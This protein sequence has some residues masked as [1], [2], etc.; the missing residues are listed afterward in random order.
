MLFA[1]YYMQVHIEP[2]KM[3]IGGEVV[4]YTLPP[5]EDQE[6]KYDAL[7]YDTIFKVSSPYFIGGLWWYHTPIL[8][9]RLKE[10]FKSLILG[11][12]QQF[13]NSIDETLQYYPD[14]L[15]NVV[16]KYIKKAYN[17][18]VHK[19]LNRSGLPKLTAFQTRLKIL[20]N[21]S[22]LPEWL[23][24]INGINCVDCIDKV[25]DKIILFL[26]NTYIFL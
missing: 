19:L 3:H 15:R 2:I 21:V 1:W 6:K 12:C 7:S 10:K 24:S 23:P 20:T 25:L 4:Q 22:E 18:L 9:R 26:S 17:V 16:Q 5:Y 14:H 11:S 8:P 13:T